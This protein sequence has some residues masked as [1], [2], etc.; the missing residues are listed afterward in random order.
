MRDSFCATGIPFT[1]ILR[2]VRFEFRAHFTSAKVTHSQSLCRRRRRWRRRRL[3]RLPRKSVQPT[4]SAAGLRSTSRQATV[5][6]MFQRT[7][8]RNN[9]DRM[10]FHLNK[11]HSIEFVILNL[12]MCFVYSVSCSV[13]LF[14]YH[15]NEN[16]KECKPTPRSQ[17]HRHWLWRASPNLS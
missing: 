9:V 16:D 4:P 1:K 7:L 3:C 8:Y 5:Q 13:A 12:V 10:D 2:Q 15:Q 6:S 14:M 17:V 11:Q